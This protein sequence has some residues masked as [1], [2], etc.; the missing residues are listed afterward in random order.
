MSTSTATVRT[1][2]RSRVLALLATSALLA[3]LVAVNPASA[4]RVDSEELLTVKQFAQYVSLKNFI[5]I[6]YPSIIGSPEVGSILTAKPPALSPTPTSRSYQWM[7]DGVIDTSIRGSRYT[8]TESDAGQRISV[9]VTSSRLGYRTFVSV[10]A[11]LLVPARPSTP[12]EEEP[13]A[14]EVGSDTEGADTP[15][16]EPTP[17]PTQD[18]PTPSPEPEE[19]PVVTPEPEPT[20]T[21]PALQEFNITT[22]PRISGTPQVGTAL[23][24]IPPRF[25]PS[26]SA[27]FRWQWFRN[28]VAIS[29]ATAT[30][31]VVTRFDV[32]A[33]LSAR[34]TL[35]RAGY[36]TT[37][38]STPSTLA[39]PRTFQD[40]VFSM[41]NS[42]RAG[43]GVQQLRPNAGLSSMAQEY[44]EILSRSSTFQHS[45]AAWRNARL[46]PGWRMNG[47]NIAAGQT[48]PSSVMTDWRNSRPH[49]E[50][51]VRSNF[52][53]LGVG[54]AY[55]PN[56]VYRHYWVQ[57]FAQ[58]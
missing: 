42:L 13:V 19:S 14:I 24:A 6:A 9:R 29:G 54:Y 20:P 21:T 57:T 30:K 18:V 36:E 4:S 34:V 55:N 23:F 52:N 58:Y 3:P 43:V 16:P 7:R 27:V 10:S 28:G 26:T 56:S 41:T 5:V 38:V 8:I 50:N 49:Y 11:S 35:I 45:T 44:A 1:K 17:E 25:S 46:A 53:H 2:W 15:T 22:N 31:Y 40:Q 39:I 32:G 12:A 33:R 48:T 51:L 37:T 47:E